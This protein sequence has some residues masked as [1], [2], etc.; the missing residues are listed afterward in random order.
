MGKKAFKP[1]LEAFLEPMF[2]CLSCGHQLTEVAAGECIGVLRDLLGPS[3]FAGRLADEQQHQMSNPNIP[4]P[5]RFGA[6]AP[7]GSVPGRPG[8]F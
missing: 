7:P 5:K 2:R 1:Y 4:P 6:A 8:A 3:I